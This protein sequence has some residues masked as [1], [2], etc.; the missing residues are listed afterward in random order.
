MRTVLLILGTVILLAGGFGAYWL[1]QRPDV[2]RAP[3]ADVASKHKPLALQESDQ[4]TYV[5]R[6]GERVW[7][8]NVDGGKLTSQFRAAQFNPQKEGFVRVAEPEAQFF[9]KGGQWIRVTGATGDVYVSGMPEKG[10]D[11][12]TSANGMSGAPSRGSLRDVH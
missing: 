9:L 3:G 4:T 11:P 6:G 10:A 8:K 2:A 12:F 5:V 1:M 7:M